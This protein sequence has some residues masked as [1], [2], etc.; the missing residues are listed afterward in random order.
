ML[1]DDRHAH[2]AGLSYCVED[3]ISVADYVAAIERGETLQSVAITNHG[4]A[5]YFPYDLAW[6]WRYMTEPALFDEH[7]EWGNR[8]FIPHLDEVDSLRG[9][10]LLTG[11]EVE[12]MADGRLTVDPRLID[13]L[14]AIVGSVHWLREEGEAPERIVAAWMAHVRAL[15]RTGIDILGHPLRMLANWVRPLPAETVPFV[16][17]VAREAGIAV[18]INSHYVVEADRELLLEAVRRDVPVTLSTDSHRFSEIGR[19]DYHLDLVA[20]AG[21]RIEDLKLWRPS[22][23]KPPSTAAAGG[24]RSLSK[25]PPA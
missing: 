21:L 4:F 1:F 10:G 16:V 23:R 9:R 15:A 20:R 12:M 11:V 17:D 6:S 5:I 24:D 13:R 19:F 22:R 3:P 25:A 7:L 2:T 8:R 18:E 14:D